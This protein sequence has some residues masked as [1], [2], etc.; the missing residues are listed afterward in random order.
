MEETIQIPNQDYATF[1][2]KNKKAKEQELTTMK[3]EYR[4]SEY[5]CTYTLQKITGY[6][7]GMMLLSTI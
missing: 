6:G 5:I 1:E 2:N 7:E 3:N 4:G